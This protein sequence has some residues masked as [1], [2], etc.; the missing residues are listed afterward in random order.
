MYQICVRGESSR[1]KTLERPSLPKAI[2]ESSGEEE[3]SEDF[4]A[5]A[6]YVEMRRN[7]ER[8]TDES[9]SLPKDEND[10]ERLGLKPA[11]SSSNE[12]GAAETGKRIG[13]RVLQYSVEETWKLCFGLKPY[14]L[15]WR[16][17]TKRGKWD[18]GKLTEYAGNIVVGPK[19]FKYIEN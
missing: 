8:N 14:S 11:G 19:L 6:T 3:P 2:N 15:V 10:R 17:S 13:R 12:P 1:F 16:K 18:K 5:N 7:T 4:H 9:P